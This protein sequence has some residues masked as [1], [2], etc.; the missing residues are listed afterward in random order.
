MKYFKEIDLPVFPDLFDELMDIFK[1]HNLS[2]YNNG[3]ICI[4][5]VSHDPDNIEL[6]TGSLHHDWSNKYTIEENGVSK[7]IVPPREFPLSDSDF[8]TLCSQFKGSSFEELYNIIKLNYN[9]GRIRIMKSEPKTCLSWHIDPTPRLHFPIKTQHGC[10][11]VV[12][13]EV[14]HMPKDTWWWVDT[15]KEHTAFNASKESRIHLVI[16]LIDQ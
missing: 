2:W 10:F 3:Q 6:G 9:V 11:M 16:C 5:T 7:I 13:D 12:E 1:K 4:N 8:D 14:V 15:T